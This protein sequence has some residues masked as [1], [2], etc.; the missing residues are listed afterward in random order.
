MHRRLGRFSRP[1]LKLET[2]EIMRTCEA[3]LERRIV[4]DLKRNFLQAKL[5]IQI[6]L[7]QKIS[8]N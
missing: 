1:K 6:R 3:F 8:P 5:E 2:T 7:L 4:L